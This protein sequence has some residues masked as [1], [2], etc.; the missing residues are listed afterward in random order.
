MCL[1][2]WFTTSE[3]SDETQV[4]FYVQMNFYSITADAKLTETSSTGTEGETRPLVL[5]KWFHNAFWA[6][7]EDRYAMEAKDVGE[8]LMI[9][10]EN[11]QSGLFHH[12]SD[13]FLD[14]VS[15]RK[16]YQQGL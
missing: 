9:K 4:N 11:D 8:L 1:P 12:S 5:E 2:P 14:V 6:G 3:N 16:G 10:V 15:V 13:L 7:Y